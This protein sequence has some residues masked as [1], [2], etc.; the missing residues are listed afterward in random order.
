MSM[1]VPVTSGLI[2][3]FQSDNIDGLNNSTLT[4]GQSISQWNDIVEVGGDATANNATA[5][6]GKTYLDSL[7]ANTGMPSFV[8]VTNSL[9]PGVVFSRGGADVA[10]VLGSN[11]AITGLSITGGFTAFIVSDLN[12]TQGGPGRMMQFGNRNGTNGAIVGLGTDG[13]RYNG[14]SKT[15]TQSLFTA[16]VNIGTYSMDLSQPVGGAGTNATYRLDGNSTTLAGG[17][18][19]NA[20]AVIGIA[21]HGFSIGAG[22]NN[23]ANPP[24]AANNGKVIDPINGTLYA[25]LLYNRVLTPTEFTQ[26]EGFLNDKFVVAIPEAPAYIILGILSVAIGG[27][28]LWRNRA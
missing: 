27:R 6:N 17:Q 10:D 19:G 26:V 9:R 20:A 24:E 16:G 14:N 28:S 23:S 21:N 22:Q 1:A 18:P 4:D 15:V 5:A 2:L 12:N 7:N 8:A 13:F 11:S 25:V 3:N